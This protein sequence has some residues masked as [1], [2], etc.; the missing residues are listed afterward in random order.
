MAGIRNQCIFA[1]LDDIKASLSVPEPPVAR[2]VKPLDQFR[3]KFVTHLR[4]R[5]LPS[6]ISDAIHQQLHLSIGNVAAE[7][8]IKDLPHPDEN[9]LVGAGGSPQLN[10]LTFGDR[11]EGWV[12]ISVKNMNTS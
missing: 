3:S 6:I 10:G 8:I 2:Y 9:P 1:W 11:M 12:W 5:S 4:L 7:W